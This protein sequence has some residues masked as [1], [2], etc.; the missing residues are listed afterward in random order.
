MEL[1]ILSKKDL[2]IL[3]ICKISNYEIN[4]DEETNAK[5]TFELIKTDSIKKGNFMVLSGLY[6]QFLFVIDDI[7]NSKNNNLITVI[8]LDISNMFNQKV[9]EKNIELMTTD[10]IEGFIAA[11]ITSNFI[12]SDDDILNIDYIDINIRTHTKGSV[13]TNSENGLYNFHTFMINCRQYKN[14]Y[15]DFSFDNKKLKIDIENKKQ[16]IKLIDATLPEVI[17][18][19]KIYE[20]DITAK[21]T[22]LIR[23]NGSEYNLYLKADRTTTTDKNDPDRVNGN[24]EVIS[25]DTVD[26]AYEEALNVIKGNSYKHLVEFKIAK[27]SKLMDISDFTIG[28]PV[29][30]KT[31]DDI[32]ESYISAIKL[33]DENF[34]YFKSG[35]L[36]ANFLEKISKNDNNIGN[37]LDITGGVIDG[38]ID[39]KGKISAQEIVLNGQELLEYE[40]IE[41]W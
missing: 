20:E 8:A 19:N 15:T 18:Y 35:K 39:L 16:S 28:R 33:S 3:D 4:F 21:V 6:K 38:N 27:S 23:E 32:Y 10:S 25:V 31:E 24:V 29:K 36:R 17:D 12:N 34:V 37:K 13:S 2:K 9:I 14:I 40:V 30:I 5:T 41:E 7:Q 11:T 1:Y 22:V 26:K